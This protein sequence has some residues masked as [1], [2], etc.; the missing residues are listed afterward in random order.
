M[1]IYP[2][3]SRLVESK[4][5]VSALHYPVV[6]AQAVLA[7]VFKSFCRASF[8]IRKREKFRYREREREKRGGF[9]L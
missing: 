5:R 9:A 8:V 1:C 4:E 3:A 6:L 7:Y 2:Y